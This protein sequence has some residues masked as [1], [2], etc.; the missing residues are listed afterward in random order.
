MTC[1]DNKEISLAQAEF[2]VFTSFPKG[3]LKDPLL[4][5]FV[6]AEMALFSDC[7]RMWNE[8]SSMKL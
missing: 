5:A 8:N 3:S 6:K 7:E 1:D 4:K 2:N